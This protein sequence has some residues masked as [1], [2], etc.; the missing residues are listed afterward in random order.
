MSTARAVKAGL[1]IT[2]FFA[3]V[4]W[5]ST[6]SSRKGLPA[7]TFTYEVVNEWIYDAPIKTQIEQHIVLSGIPT[8]VELRAEIL[9]RYR[10]ARHRRGFR[11]HNQATNIYIYIYGT[12][13]QARTEGGG[14]IGM[15][16]T[17]NGDKGE[18][19]ILIDERRLAALSQKP[20]DRFGLSEP[21]RKRVFYETAAA[22]DK[23]RCEA[24]VRAPDLI[25]NELAK[26][27]RR[28]M[29]GPI[30]QGP[31]S[32]I[33]KQWAK[34]NRKQTSLIYKLQEKY[35]VRI[36][37]KYNLTLGQLLEITSEGVTMGWVSSRPRC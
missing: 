37:R 14:W 3:S 5:I 36:A 30:A 10:S 9:K 34:Q 4:V 7:T 15:L 27:Q 24:R 18:A 17:R 22:E 26:A 28:K 20:E 8:E 1:A 23:A 13:E 16:A 25:L 2:L 33:M 32:A 11:Y 19:R 31:G 21:N 29:G 12:K 6:F 35:R